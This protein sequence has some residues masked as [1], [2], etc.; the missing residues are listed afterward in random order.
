MRFST[1]DDDGNW[2][3][4]YEADDLSK[5]LHDTINYY[6]DMARKEKNRGDMT[7]EEAKKQ[8]KNQYEEENKQLKKNAELV[9]LRF[10]S[11]KERDAYHAFEQ[12]HKECRGTS[13]INGGKMPYLIPYGTGV[14]TA[15]TA[16]CPICG[17]KEDITDYTSW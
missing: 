9:Y 7:L 4:I 14:G 5:M 2:H 17:E 11:Y 12:K 8:V 16:I 10:N 1:M 13:R 3:E 15:Y 6:R